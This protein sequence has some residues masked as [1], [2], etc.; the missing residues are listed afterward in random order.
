MLVAEGH[1][2]RAA[3]KAGI[4]QPAMSA[5]LARL[6][7]LFN[8]P[9]LV[10][11]TISMQPTPRAYELA[12][13]AKVALELLRDGGGPAQ[14]FDPARAEAHIRIM[15]SEGVAEVVAPD[16]LSIV[17]R[18]APRLR[19]TIRSG[20][21]R[22]SA[23]YLR[24]G[25]LEFAM[26]FTN[27]RVDEFHQMLLYPQRIMCLVSRQHPRI[28]EVLTLDHFLAE[29]HVVWGAEPIPHPALENL[30]DQALDAVGSTRKVV[31]RV[32]SLSVSAAL[33]ARTDLLAVVPHRL[34][35]RP[36]VTG[37]CR[38][39]PLPFPTEAFDVQL[40]WHARWHREPTHAWLRKAFRQVAKDLQIQF[41]Q[42]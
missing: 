29:G 14:A 38:I 25:E 35:N 7:K 6:R 34:A 9:I 16:L 2:T 27:Q 20:D 22:R 40:L 41:A 33:V 31:A 37:P 30:V 15:A 13:K 26:A 5:A 24:D 10:R 12:E 36:D 17:R 1:V 42:V 8:D 28:Q 32:S 4:S 18:R 3:D 21:I 19:I 23:E 39:L 11:T